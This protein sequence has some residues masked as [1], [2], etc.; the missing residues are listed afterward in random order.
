[1]ENKVL[2]CV[3]CAVTN[4]NLQNK[5]Y[6]D[7]CLTT[8]M[9]EEVLADAM[10]LYEEDENRR[11]M[12]AAGEKPSLNM[13]F[14]GK[15]AISDFV[16]GQDLVISLFDVQVQAVQG[17]LGIDGAGIEG[18]LQIGDLKHGPSLPSVH[19]WDAGICVW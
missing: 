16:A 13:Y 15:N 17:G 10:K 7:F 6:P 18:L 2:S 1:M 8:H 11:S 4:C 9:D 3:D 19:P 12:I 14:A 5:E